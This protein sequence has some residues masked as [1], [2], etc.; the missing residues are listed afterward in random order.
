MA[1]PTLSAGVL[2]VSRE[3]QKLL[4]DRLREYFTSS[5]PPARAAGIEDRIYVL[6]TPPVSARPPFLGV[7]DGI[8]RPE[9]EGRDMA[10]GTIEIHLFV[11]ADTLSVRGGFSLL[12][13]ENGLLRLQ[14]IIR[15][16]VT[17][18]AEPLGVQSIVVDRMD[19]SAYFAQDPARPRERLLQTKVLTAT[20]LL[21]D[22]V[23]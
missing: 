21:Y 1:A 6:G 2:D 22:P 13:D 14:R 5:D 18:A 3:P 16:L 17:D 20:Y 12:G 15:A 19:G 8:V 9:G 7:K 23:S 4:L 10:V 11:S